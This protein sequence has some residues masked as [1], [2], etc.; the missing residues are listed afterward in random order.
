MPGAPF[1]S[2]KIANLFSLTGKQK[3]TPQIQIQPNIKQKNT[4]QKKNN[5]K[6]NKST[7][8]PSGKQKGGAIS[9]SKRRYCCDKPQFLRFERERAFCIPPEVT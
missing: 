9:D 1:E 8:E 7:V 5:N 2:S 4:Y 6:K 3:R